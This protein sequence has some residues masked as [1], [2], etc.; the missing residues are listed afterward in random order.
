MRIESNPPRGFSRFLTVLFS[1]LKPTEKA[2]ES[3]VAFS[4]FGP[5]SARIVRA[6]AEELLFSSPLRS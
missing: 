2:T 6:H 4:G 3:S 5:S 1:N